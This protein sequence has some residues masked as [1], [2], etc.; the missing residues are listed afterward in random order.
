V[1]KGKLIQKR[2]KTVDIEVVTISPAFILNKKDGTSITGNAKKLAICKSKGRTEIVKADNPILENLAVHPED[3]SMDHRN[4]QMR[5]K[6]IT[7]GGTAIALAKEAAI[8]M[9]GKKNIGDN[10]RFYRKNGDRF[11]VRDDNLI[12]KDFASRRGC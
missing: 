1:N 4:N 10:P 8:I 3:Y 11:D 9:R 7:Q 6:S 12:M 2:R 5:H